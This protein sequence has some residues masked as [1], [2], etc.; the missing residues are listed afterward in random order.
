MKGCLVLLRKVARDKLVAVHLEILD[1]VKEDGGQN[2]LAKLIDT[3]FV[4]DDAD[5]FTAL[6]DRQDIKEDG[7]CGFSVAYVTLV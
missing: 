1:L 6:D 2:H 7:S 4:G 5:V 3:L